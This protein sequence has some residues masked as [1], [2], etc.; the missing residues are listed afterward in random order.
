MGEGIDSLLK[1]LVNK[2]ENLN[3]GPTTSSKRQATI[4]KDVAAKK[5]KNFSYGC[6]NWLPLALPEGE[7]TETQNETKKKCRICIALD[8]KYVIRRYPN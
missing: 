6:S 2:I 1:Q 7:T 4:E 8:R 5:P 3:R